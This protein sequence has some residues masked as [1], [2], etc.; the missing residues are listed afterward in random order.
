MPKSKSKDAPPKPLSKAQIAQ[1]MQ[2][3]QEADKFKKLIR[4]GIFP[5]LKEL[6]NVAKAQQVAEILKTVIDAKMNEYWQDKTVEDLKLIDQLEEEEKDGTFQ[7]ADT[8]KKLITVMQGLSIGDAHKL[9]EGMGGAFD[10]YAR[11]LAMEKKMEEVSASDIIN[12]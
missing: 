11:K 7:G 10:G 2:L 12:D 6:D 3:K 4:E 9:L 5:I 8:F 1:Q